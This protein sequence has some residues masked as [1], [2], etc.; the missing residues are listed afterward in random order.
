[1][2]ISTCYKRIF[3]K[4]IQIVCRVGKINVKVILKKENESLICN[5]D[6]IASLKYFQYNIFTKLD[7]NPSKNAYISYSADTSMCTLTIKYLA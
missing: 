3:V 1:L 6:E 5:I 2:N 4:V 7:G